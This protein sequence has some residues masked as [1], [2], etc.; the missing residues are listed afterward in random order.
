MVARR[1]LPTGLDLVG[2]RVAS[3]VEARQAAADG[4]NL[5]ILEV[6]PWTPVE[7]PSM[8]CDCHTA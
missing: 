1:S 8:A 2:R 4:A 6:G 3:G 7:G 5:V